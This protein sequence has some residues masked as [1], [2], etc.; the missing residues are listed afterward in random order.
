[1]ICPHCGE[2]ARCKGFRSRVL[3]GLLG[4]M[5]LT[6]HYYHC[7]CGAGNSPLD[8]R[9]RLQAHDLT[10]GAQ[11]VVCLL[12]IQTS[13]ADAAVKLLPRA[14]ALRV[15][16][17]TVER[18]TEATGARVGRATA[19]GQTFGPPKDWAW[20]KDAEGK[21]VA[22]ASVDATGVGQQGPCGA[23]AEGRMAVVGMVYNPV[24]EDRHR[25]AN[26]SGKRPEWQ[27]NY[28]AQLTPLAE[29]A[30]PLRALGAQAGMDRAERWIA[31]SDGGAGVEDFL[32]ANFGR[33]DEVI[34]DFWHASEYLGD[35]SRALHPGQEEASKAWCSQWCSK[36]KAEGGEAVR[37]QLRGLSVSRSASEVHAEVLRY[38]ENQKHR[39]D[40]PRYVSKG[41]QIGSGPVESACKSVVGQRLKGTGMRWGVEGADG[42]C[43][44]RAVFRSQRR[45]WEAFWN[46]S[47]N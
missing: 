35:L 32:R 23:K 27:A 26:P 46:P 5:R 14:C 6:R 47:P 11:E 29:L 39:M 12:G 9:L 4:P 8:A 1:M 36:L 10:A 22:Y 45:N 33:V 38:F 37:A 24:P 28:V 25:W 41:W 21:T 2:D 16:E 17:S 30:T 40:Y 44:L 42:V 19:A 31:L 3:V 7:P 18:V 13:F 15:S 43:Q 20:H 34:L